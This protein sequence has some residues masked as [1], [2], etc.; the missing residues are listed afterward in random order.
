MKV[1]VELLISSSL[2]F[3]DDAAEYAINSPEGHFT[4]TLK[5]YASSKPFAKRSIVAVLV[6]EIDNLDQARDA[7]LD[8][9]ATVQNAL[10]FATGAVFQEVIVTKAFDWERGKVER[11]AAYYATP[12][13]TLSH[14]VLDGSILKSAERVMAMHGDE[15]CQAIM[16]WYR[17]GIRSDML[18]EQFSYFWFAAEIAAEA[19]K[20]TGKIAPKCP[21]CNSDLFC[22]NCDQTPLRKRFSAEAIED[23]IHSA[24]PPAG[25][26]DELSK[27]LFKIRNTLQHGRRMAS[28]IDT[29]PCTEEQAVNVMARIA[30]RAIARLADSD[31][32]TELEEPLSFI[33]QDEVHRR[34]MVMTANIVTQLMGTEHDNPKME[35]APAIKLSMV[36][37]RN[38]YTFD[39]VLID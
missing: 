16:R 34:T 28:I 18:E 10:T 14:P 35:N 22:P 36:V 7:A 32:D 23:L 11:Q 8:H 4:V 30:W 15:V 17:L 20:A 39:G 1:A 31:A 21:S 3:A 33:I 25:N 29:L 2:C 26:K 27:T 13:A 6:F 5:N 24:A 19:L 9:F 38:N 37:D 12:E